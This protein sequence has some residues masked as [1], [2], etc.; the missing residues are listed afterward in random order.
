MSFLT[1]LFGDPNAKVVKQIEP[2]VAK[3]NTLEPQIATL[4]LENLKE[5]TTDFKKRFSEGETLDALLPEAFAVVREVSKRLTG[6]RHFDVQLMG[7]TVLHW[8]QIA[9]MHTGEGKTLT[10]TLAVYLNA[11]SGEGVHVVTVNDYLAKRDA[12]WMGQIYDAL[13]LTVGIIQNQLVSYRYNSNK[14][15]VDLSEG[16][17]DDKERDEKGAF[18]VEYDYLD[19]CS[20]QEAYQCDIVYGTN[21]EFGFDYLR[22]NMVS[23]LDDV[24]QRKLNFAIVDEVDSILIDEARTPLIISAPAEEAADQYYRFADL[25]E[26]LKDHE[27]YNVDEKMRASTLTDV[28]LKKMEEWLNIEN[29]YAEGGIVMVHHIE[30]ALKAKALFK[31]DRDYVVENNEVVIVDEFTGRKMPGRRYSEGLHQAIEAK[32]KVAIQRESRTMATITFQNYFRMYK[33]LSGMTGTAVT[34]AEEF[35]KIY[36]L[37][38]VV[39]PTNKQGSRVD[40]SDKIFKTEDGKFKAIAKQVKEL[41]AQGQPVLIGTVSVE[42][43]EILATYLEQEG[44]KYE[45]LNAKNHEREGEII[46]QAG[47]PGAVTLATNMAGR[48]VD[49][50]LGGNP[51]VA[52]DAEK[53]RANGGLFVIGTERHESRRIDN[54]L[55]GRS[56]RQGDPGRTQFYLSTEDDLMRIFAGDRIKSVM[57]TLRVPDDMPIEQKSISRIIESAQKKVEGFHFDTRK[58]LLDYD[59]VLNRHRE[60]VYGNRRKVLEEYEAEKNA[61]REGK[62]LPGTNETLRQMIFKMIEAEIE[63]IVSFHTNAEDR[64]V[65][66]LKELCG[67]ISTI[68]PLSDEEQS[69]II[70]FASRGESKLESVEQRTKLIEHIS[71]LAQK[72]YEQIVVQKAAFPELIIELER[73]VLLRSMDNLWID[74]LVAVDYLRT[75]I[76]LRGYGQRDPLVEYKKETYRMFNELLSAIQK[77]VVYSVYKI[78]I[79][80]ELAPSIIEKGNLNFQGAEKTTVTDMPLKSDKPT[81]AEGKEIGRNDVCFCGSGKKYKKCAMINSQE[82]QSKMMKK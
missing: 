46:A 72:K 6:M 55:R 22:D 5:K 80:T 30:Q 4:S 32:E 51:P 73:Q 1:K 8:G 79:G 52:A 27:D 14:K 2:I 41:Q 21:N 70:A 66:D 42:K 48:G 71:E 82:H 17:A 65:W 62:E 69:F 76:G 39:V 57:Q 78:S 43:N 19:Q 7:A 34:E 33:K 63:Q 38:V 77:E 29:I 49:I 16:S 20:R 12:V 54:Q 81:T 50:I 18:K 58:H 68:F 61:L 47:K 3:I 40:N 24:S 23:T 44:V 56:G 31:R 10:A 9:E 13:G 64:G 15:Q 59:D 35:G 28:G 53:V 11:L 75:G 25:V 45:V 74:H 67:T 37:E 26:R 60:V 36:K